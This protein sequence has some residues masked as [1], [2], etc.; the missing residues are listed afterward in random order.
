MAFNSGFYKLSLFI[1][2]DTISEHVCAKAVFHCDTSIEIQLQKFPDT[3]SR[4]H[5]LWELMGTKVVL[6]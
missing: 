3:L 6:L 4:R 2:W 5:V 1:T